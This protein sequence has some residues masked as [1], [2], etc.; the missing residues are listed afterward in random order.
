LICVE[1]AATPKNGTSGPGFNSTRILKASGP[2]QF[3][4]KEQKA[5]K[6]KQFQK[7]SF[8]LHPVGTNCIDEDHFCSIWANLGEC[9]KNPDHMLTVCRK[10]CHVCDASGAASP[11]VVAMQTVKNAIMA[12]NRQFQ[13]F[14]ELKNKHDPCH[15]NSYNILSN[16]NRAPTY[17][18]SSYP[19]CDNLAQAGGKTD[20]QWKGAGYYRFQGPFTRM[21]TVGEANATYQCG[22]TYP[23][24]I[25]DPTIYKI[26]VGETKESVEVCFLYGSNYCYQRTYISMTYCVGGFYI[27]KLPDALPAC[28]FGYCGA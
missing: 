28:T 23:G 3:E 8:P 1:S 11:L 26:R 24:F 5:L 2:I 4:S 10:S 15:S 9:S 12:L 17:K 25:N 20:P 19:T 16:P 14:Q 6:T 13:Q 7:Q 18:N 27:Y 21:A 22:T